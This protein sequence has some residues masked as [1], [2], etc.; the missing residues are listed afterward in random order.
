M[1][2][3]KELWVN[4]V[5]ILLTTLLALIGSFTYAYLSKPVYEY[6]V[7]VVPPA[8]GSI[9]GF[10]IGRREN[11]LDAY[12]VRSIYAIFSLYLPQVGEGAESED[13][14]E[15]FYKKF[16]KEVKIDPANKPDADRYTVIVEGTKREV[17]ATWA[18]AFVRLAAD[19][20][21]HEVID[22]AGR[23]FQVRNAAMQSR[24]TVL[25]NMAK[26][27][28]DDRIA[29]LKEAL[30]IA[31]SL[32]ID[33][34]PLIEGAS[35][36]QLSSIMDGD[37]MYMR[38]AKA[39]RAEINNLESRSVDAP[40]IPELRTL[41]EKLSWNSSLSV[42]SDAVAVYKEDEGLSFSNQPIKPKKILIVTIGTLAGL[43]IGILLA[44]LA[45]FISKLRSD[46][47]LR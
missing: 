25:Q 12:T 11:G 47:S 30:L 43:I 2:L 42:D 15:E 6:R 5:L 27:R 28:R 21:V 7:A 24:I 22:S 41:Q 29:R 9:E 38:G 10:N 1:K 16:S 4:K 37:L 32:K 39:L 35:E 17:L 26:G 36:Q 3:V 34:P 31:E 14:Q 40:F 23:D 45:G 19:R 18:Q 46:G 44:V 33:G 8:L 13:E 20:A